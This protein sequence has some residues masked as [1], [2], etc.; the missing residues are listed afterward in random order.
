MSGTTSPHFRWLRS[1]VA[2][3]ALT[4]GVGLGLGSFSPGRAYAAPTADPV[5]GAGKVQADFNGDG[6]GDLAVIA[7]TTYDEVQDR[8]PFG[9]V[10]VLYGSASGLSTTGR[11]RIVGGDLPGMGT[12]TFPFNPGVLVAGD[13]NG[14]GASELAIGWRGGLAGSASGAGLVYVVPGS[15]AGLRV[16]ATRVW[17]QATKGVQGSPEI[18]DGFGTALAAADFGGG[19]EADLA[20]GV[21]G[22]ALGS[23][24]DAGMVHVLYGS[25][26]GLT[27]A[28]DQVWTQDSSKVPGV[29]ESGDVFGRGL[30]AGNFDGRHKAD[31]AVSATNERVHGAYQAGAVS[32]LY[33]STSRLSASGSQTWT[34]DS[35]GISGK[36]Q[37]RDYFGLSLA[38]GTLSSQTRDDLAIAAPGEVSSTHPDRGVV[39]VLRSSASGLTAQGSQLW[40]LPKVG[41]T[42]DIFHGFGDSLLAADFGRNPAGQRYGDLLIGTRGRVDLD[43]P[44]SDYLLYGGPSGA[45]THQ[46]VVSNGGAAAA[47][48]N[49]SS[50]AR[51][52]DL[53]VVR[54]A[55][56]SEPALEVYPGGADGLSQANPQRFTAADLGLPDDPRGQLSL[57]LSAAGSR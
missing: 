13:F 51:Y 26:G 53:A 16:S 30:V 20:I 52:A 55:L 12:Q 28:G 40:S 7:S 32:V 37:Y 47:D 39:H 36:P 6:F 43:P 11:Q 25:S 24:S 3:A 29:A 48:F 17:S 46:P 33:S 5:L 19:P 22:E 8:R 49:T 14:D 44:T 21:D 41:G 27:A 31:L 35:P 56:D 9:S 54:T 45:A 34:Q 10:T 38:A 1:C 2:V 57:R 50:G 42:G 23:K 18:G 4:L 15:A